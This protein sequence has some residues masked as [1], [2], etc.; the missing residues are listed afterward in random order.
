VANEDATVAAYSEHVFGSCVWLS[1]FI[2]DALVGDGTLVSLPIKLN[3]I[4][5]RQSSLDLVRWD[6]SLKR[7]LH[8]Q[9]FLHG[10]YLFDFFAFAITFENAFP[11]RLCN[12]F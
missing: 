8:Y 10:A 1:A 11:L 9:V 3:E 5:I 12:H 4:T 2:R 7:D 6:L